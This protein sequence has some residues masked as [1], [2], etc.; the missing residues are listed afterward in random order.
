[1]STDYALVLLLSTEGTGVSRGERRL[2]TS[3]GMNRCREFERGENGFA[4]RMFVKD[5]QTSLDVAMSL[6]PT[7]P[8]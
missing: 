1:M 2:V 4:I 6:E 8:P 7:Y 3:N 5:E